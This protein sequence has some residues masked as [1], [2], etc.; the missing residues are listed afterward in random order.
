ME[1]KDFIKLAGLGI[2]AS[3]GGLGFKSFAEEA[4]SLK[5]AETK[6]PA[7]FI[8][9]GSPM[10]A[11][12]DNAV[13]RALKK[14]GTELPRPKAVL[15]VSAHWL[16]RGTHVL[17]AAKPKMIY[18]MYGFPDALYKVKYEAPGSPEFAKTVKETSAKTE[19]KLNDEWGFDHGNWSVMTHLFPKADI[20]AFQLSIDYHKSPQYHYDLAAELAKL[21]QKGILV[22]GSGNMTHNLGDFD[23]SSED[24]KPKDWALEFDTKMKNFLDS[25]DH[26]SIINYEKLGKIAKLSHPEPS[27]FQPLLYAIGM[28]G[29]DEK[30]SYPHEGI[31]YGTMS[32]RCVKI[33]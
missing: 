2:V 23:I 20:P 28:Q 24:G 22:I 8:G 12:E 16:T 32:M 14:L 7:L 6:M 17:S 5:D 30:L 19:I 15:V 29:K 27:H 31:V 33:G 18:D 10:N 3:A 13:T 1:R 21:R 25:H 11:I 9:H 4:A 26:T